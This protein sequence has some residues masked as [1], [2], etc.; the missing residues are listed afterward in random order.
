MDRHTH[1]MKGRWLDRETCGLVFVDG[2]KGHKDGQ[3]NR[4]IGRQTNKSTHGVMD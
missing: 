4:Q 2:T 3:T 1:G